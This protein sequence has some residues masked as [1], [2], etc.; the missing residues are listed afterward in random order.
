MEK[1]KF[2]DFEFWIWWDS[3]TEYEKGLVIGK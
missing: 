3:L 1:D 2:L